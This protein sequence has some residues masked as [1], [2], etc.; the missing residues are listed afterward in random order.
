MP[1]LFG[2]SPARKKPIAGR[3]SVG[4]VV[5][6]LGLAATPGGAAPWTVEQARARVQ[7]HGRYAA[8]T[9]ASGARERA[10]GQAALPRNNP[11]LGYQREQSFGATATGTGA[12]FSGVAENYLW[13]GHT[14]DLSFR[15]GLLEEAGD[16]RAAAAA[17]HG[18]ARERDALAHVEHLFFLTLA[19]GERAAAHG[20]WIDRLQ[21]LAERTRAREAK[22]DASRYDVL[23]IERELVLAE[24]RRS[25]AQLQRTAA[26]AELA[27]FLDEEPARLELVGEL[28][29]PPPPEAKDLPRPL[30]ARALDEEGRALALEHDAA[31][32][33]YLPPVTATAGGKTVFGHQGVAP[34]VGEVG[35]LFTVQVPLPTF[36]RGGARRDELV[37]AQRVAAAEAD[38]EVERVRQRAAA[39]R[40]VWAQ[41]LATLDEHEG[42]AAV[43][44]ADLVQT[45][46]AAWAGGELSLLALLE[47]ERTSLDDE[48]AALELRLTARTAQVAWSALTQ[49]ANP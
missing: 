29:P 30:P 1:P 32:R 11:F 17:L 43:R 36:E 31:G 21:D 24:Q 13:L 34:Q 2:P 47:A 20:R 48:L 14:F 46:R 28:R 4:A 12:T 42:R 9:D 10:R 25:E 18:E 40:A 35:Y 3:C 49:E 41:A 8:W 37:A 45:A 22:G 27:A 26:L 38:L 16:R 33:W 19:F 5:V 44:T 39:A 23:R 15:R 6:L 7:E